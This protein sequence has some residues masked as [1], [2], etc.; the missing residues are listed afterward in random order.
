LG[1]PEPEQVEA[2][3]RELDARERRMPIP[4]IFMPLYTLKCD[5]KTMYGGRG[6]GKS[7]NVARILLLKAAEEKLR[8]VC[9]REEM[10]SIADSV[11]RLFSD[12]IGEYDLGHQFTVQKDK[13]IGANGSLFLFKGL[14]HNIS[15]IKS[16]EGADI[17]WVEEAEN[18]SDDSWEKLIPTIRKEGSEIWI[19]FNTRYA[20]DPTYKRF[21]TTKSDDNWCQKVSWRDNP[22]FQNS[23]LNKKRLAL[24]KEDPE[25]YQHVWEGEIDA[26]KT[27]FIYNKQINIAREEGRIGNF[28][29]D[30]GFPVYTSWDLGFGDSTSIWFFQVIGRG[31]RFIDQFSNTGEEMGYYIRDVLNKRNYNYHRVSAYLPH[32]G[33]HG[34]V[35]GKSPSIQLKDLGYPNIVLPQRSAG[36]AAEIEMT[37]QMLAYAEFNEATTKD[38]VHALEHYKYEYDTNRKIF[39][40]SPRHDWASHDADS[41]C[42]AAMS[43][44]Q[45]KGVR[46]PGA[47]RPR[48]NQR[49]R[50]SSGTSWMSA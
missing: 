40:K 45:M 4:K 49:H 25:A 50:G 48:G 22:F 33:G 2:T 19:S 37:R 24:L 36:L 13:I 47:K 30:P 44:D 35:R 41:L 39:K 28:P 15:S 12:I 10:N 32:D 23:T 6:A 3:L 8:V 43:V 38:A 21:V 11:H 1:L 46:V 17:C 14:K 26:R 34:N 16:L 5:Y 9:A 18:V 31:V 7:H 20:S 29:Y 27:G 42:Y